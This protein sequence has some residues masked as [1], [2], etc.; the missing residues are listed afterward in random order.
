MSRTNGVGDVKLLR[1]TFAAFPTGVTV[2]TVGGD[3]P[4]AMT[5]NSFTSLS[6]DPPLALI[7]VGHQ[8]VMHGRLAAGHFGVSVLGVGQEALARRFAD[9]SR[10][11]GA[12][13]FDGV[14]CDPGPATGVPLISGALARF[15]CRLWRTYEGGDH[16]IFIG[17]VLSMDRPSRP[18]EDEALLFYEG[19]FRRLEPERSEVTA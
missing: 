7:C 18:E 13:Q 5:A 9:L 4:H 17:E 8:A 3:S 15:E 19:R 2:V 10:P 14:D 12:A 16:S 6:L 11:L 1:R